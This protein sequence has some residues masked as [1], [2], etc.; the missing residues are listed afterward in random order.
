MELPL[1]NLLPVDLCGRIAEL[2]MAPP[3]RN[4][5]S[6]ENYDMKIQF[7][8]SRK[9]AKLAKRKIENEKL[10]LLHIV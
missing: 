5:P 3:N 9:A 1:V 6:A 2:I 8:S 7:R 10:R 4:D